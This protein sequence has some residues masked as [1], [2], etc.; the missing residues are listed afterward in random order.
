MITFCNLYFFLAH[1]KPV[2][3][4]M[5]K[6][7]GQGGVRGVRR[8]PAPAR[9]RVQLPFDREPPTC[10]EYVPIRVKIN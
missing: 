9:R 8:S 1:I 7:P 5:G 4:L 3:S 2:T 6:T 10:V